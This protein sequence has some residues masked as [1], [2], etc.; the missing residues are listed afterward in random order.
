M[1]IKILFIDDNPDYILF[2]KRILQGAADSYQ[3][4]CV[5]DAREGL[6]RILQQDYEVIL[7]DYRMPGLSALDILKE[8][9]KK[10]K[11]LP[12]IVV[13]VYGD[14][15]AA[16]DLMKEGA[17]DYILKDLSYEEALPLVIKRSNERYKMKKE[18][19][20]AEEALEKAYYSL[21]ETQ[22]QLIQSGKMAAMGQ[23][24]SGISHELN[25]PLAGIKGFAQAALIDLDENN[26]LRG[27]L[28]KI[29]EQVERMDKI[30]KNV[31]FFARKSEFKMEA[32]SINKPIKDSCMLLAQQLKVHNIQLNVSL[33]KNL[34]KI[35]GDINQLE[36]VF[37]NL[38]SNARDAIDSLKASKGGKITI[39]TAV[40]KNKKNLE[41]TFED[42]GSGISKENLEHV[43][44]PFFTTK[45][46]D[47]GIGL[48]L[49]IIY[50]IIEA[51]QG[52]IEVSSLKGKWTKF[53]IILPLSEGIKRDV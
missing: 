19:Q 18:K 37:L 6:N 38:I 7:C 32:V 50:R 53:R 9:R 15:R 14:I 44:N 4:D 42:T 17:Y 49:S 22:E 34:P 11:D 10:G 8:I 26:P 47:G 1:P 3:L 27:D 25:Q 52:K 2:T 39:K 48:G 35:K 41:V 33:G 31:R 5:T 21:K 23:L 12:F 46:T 29:L 13:T 43:F 40:S 24:A 45:S 30:I 16:V 51:H 28:D 36:Q 20:R